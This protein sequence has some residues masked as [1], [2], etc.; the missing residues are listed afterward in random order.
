MC[1][2]LDATNLSQYGP[3]LACICLAA[4]AAAIRPHSKQR[5]LMFSAL[6]GP[7]GKP[8]STQ[9]RIDA[10]AFPLAVLMCLSVA[11]PTSGPWD[12]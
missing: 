8:Q 1:K 10:F 4:S 6:S 3:D 2:A 5:P 7:R 12:A 11:F 9:W